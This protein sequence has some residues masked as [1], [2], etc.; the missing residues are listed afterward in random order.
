MTTSTIKPPRLLLLLDVLAFL[1]AQ[2]RFFTG[3][4]LRTDRADHG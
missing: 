4:I 2:R 1:G 3:D